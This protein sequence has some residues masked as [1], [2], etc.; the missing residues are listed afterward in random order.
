VALSPKI[1]K[2]AEIVN[3]ILAAARVNAAFFRF[4]PVVKVAN[5]RHFPE[6]P[7]PAI[8]VHGMP[9]ILMAILI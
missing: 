8:I 4:D 2:P 3:E 1:A 5:L 9:A 6:D 7:L